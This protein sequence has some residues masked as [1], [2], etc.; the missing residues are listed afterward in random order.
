MGQSHF[1]YVTFSWSSPFA[2]TSLPLSQA[3]SLT[4][5][6]PGV[7]QYVQMSEVSAATNVFSFTHALEHSKNILRGFRKHFYDNPSDSCAR[8]LSGGRLSRN[9]F[10]SRMDSVIDNMRSGQFMDFKTSRY[11]EQMFGVWTHTMHG[12]FEVYSGGKIM[13]NRNAESHFQGLSLRKQQESLL[14][15]LGH[16]FGAAGI[17]END[18]D[19]RGS[20]PHPNNVLV[21]QNCGHLLGRWFHGR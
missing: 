13:M 18:G 7:Q 2:P 10:R 21:Q 4:R 20:G 17:W 3:M 8:W 11:G 12:W 1:L 15:E 9:Q 6:L 14:H 5:S 19:Y 16:I